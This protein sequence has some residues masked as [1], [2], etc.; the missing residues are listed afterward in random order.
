MPSYDPDSLIGRTFFYQKTTMVS[1]SKKIMETSQELDDIHDKTVDNINFLIKVGQG[2]SKTILS[3]DQILDHLEQENQQDQFY[4]YRAITVHK[5]PL[6]KKDPSYKG[7]L[8]I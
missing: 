6:S 8:Y 3:Y 2:R 1:V 7:C 5:G 4:N